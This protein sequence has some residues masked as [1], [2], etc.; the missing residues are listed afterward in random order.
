M[1]KMFKIA[2]IQV[3]TCILLDSLNKE[4]LDENR[5]G[6]TSKYCY[7]AKI[8]NRRRNDEC[9]CPSF[10]LIFQFSVLD[11]ACSIVISYTIA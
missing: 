6:Q 8:L 1:S 3:I 4:K 5:Q 10:A 7:S 9:W 11:E 2:I